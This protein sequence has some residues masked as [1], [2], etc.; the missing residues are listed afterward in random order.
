VYLCALEPK[1]RDGS[2]GSCSSWLNSSKKRPASLVQKLNKIARKTKKF[3]P[4]KQYFLAL[5]NFFARAFSRLPS[6]AGILSNIRDKQHVF[7]SNSIV[8]NTLRPKITQT[9]VY[10]RGQEFFPGLLYFF[11]KYLQLF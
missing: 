10:P 9:A 5:F 6:P 1:V 3:L 2:C 7:L 4:D 11:K 8:F